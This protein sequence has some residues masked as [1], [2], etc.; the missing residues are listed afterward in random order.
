MADAEHLALLMQ[1]AATWNQWRQEH[2][3]I[4][5]N[6]SKAQLCGVDLSGAHLHGADFSAAQLRDANLRRADLRKARL[7]RADLRWANLHEANLSQ[8]RLNEA[9]LSGAHLREADLSAANLGSAN[10]SMADLRRA[11]LCQAH[12]SGAYLLMARLREADL[13]EADL[14]EA[15]LRGARLRAA[16]L[17]GS[18]LHAANLCWT[19]FSMA[20]LRQARLSQ[21]DL[22]WANLSMADLQ[23]A[24]LPEADLRGANFRR[25]NLRGANLI[26]ARLVETNFEEANLEGC[27][28]YGISAWEVKLKGANQ[29][30]LR[31]T[32]DDALA[33]TVDNF[34]V[35]QFI[36]LQLHNT[37]LRDIIGTVGKKVVLILG[38]FAQERQPVLEAMREVLRQHHYVPLLCEVGSTVPHEC[39]ETVTL[40]AQLARFVL[41]DLT[42][43]KLGG[44]EVVRSAQNIAVP[45]KP[46]LLKSAGRVP[47]T[48][49]KLRAQHPAWLDT[50]RYT[51]AHDLRLSLLKECI[52]P[53]EAS[54]KALLEAMIP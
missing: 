28:I 7:H 12:L 44:E 36:Y 26:N 45:V 49:H 8:A 16:N 47:A 52:A 15:N 9:D 50:Y 48:L 40:L 5:P 29:S 3:K 22:R 39:C 20:D 46:V 2:P 25:A 17:R 34:E 54:A 24:R 1:G 30:N 33:I 31:I 10:L 51:D 6:F 13:G 32:P 4:L 41:V 21:A 53:A 19:S 23:E 14:R 37:H 42:D 43:S 27:A 18:N 11:R 38:Q 35:A